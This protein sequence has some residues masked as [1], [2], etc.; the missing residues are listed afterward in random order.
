MVDNSKNIQKEKEATPKAIL[1]TFLATFVSL[2]ITFLIIALKNRLAKDVLT[3]V[4]QI[5]FWILLLVFILII[6]HNLRVV[7]L[8]TVYIKL[9]EKSYEKG[10]IWLLLFIATMGS[11]VFLVLGFGLTVAALYML[12]YSFLFTILGIL[13]L[14]GRLTEPKDKKNLNAVW[15]VIIDIICIV[16]WIVILFNTESLDSFFFV[17]III[18]LIVSHEF[19]KI[20]M[21]PFIVRIKE[22]GVMIKKSR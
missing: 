6:R 19:Y 22:F 21:N 7:F 15:S 2:T 11:I 10:I 20:F 9:I 1:V 16:A 8:D 4:A 17:S 18:L 12:I 13:M 3:E 14:A 5:N